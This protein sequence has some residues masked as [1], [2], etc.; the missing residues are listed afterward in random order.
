MLYDYTSRINF[1]NAERT[2][3][4]VI[5]GHVVEVYEYNDSVKKENGYVKNH[6]WTDEEKERQNVKRSRTRTMTTFRRLALSNFN[7]NSIFL[8]LTFADTDDLD[9]KDVEHTNK[10][11][12]KFIQRMRR[13]YGDFKY[14]AVIEFQDKNDR[15]AVHYHLL[16]DGLPFI[17]HSK[18]YAEKHGLDPKF[19]LTDLW[20]LGHVWV[21]RIEHVDNIGAYMSKYM[22]KDLQDNRLKGKKAYLYSKNLIQPIEYTNHEIVRALVNAWGLDELDPDYKNTWI[23]FRGEESDYMN[24]I[25]YREYNLGRHE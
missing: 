10:E 22:T 20:G 5:S 21:N 8:T 11:F 13:T 14:L 2:F 1:D 12:K 17:P 18:A 6:K 16:M 24:Q 19:N 9:I 7:N 25:I 23:Q 3:K 15:G 4:I